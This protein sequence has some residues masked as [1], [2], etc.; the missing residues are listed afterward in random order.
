MPGHLQDPSSQWDGRY[1][2]PHQS[3]ER[4]AELQGPWVPFG[5]FDQAID[6]F[7]DGSFWIIRAPGHMP[8]NLCAAARVHGGHWIVLGSDC[9]HSREIYKGIHDFGYFALPDGRAACLHADV[10]AAR[11]T[12]ERITIMETVHGAHIAFAHDA[13]WMVAAEDPVLMSLL[14]ERLQAAARERIP[15]GEVA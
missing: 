3:T 6:Y 5:P 15:F 11:D 4:W 7:Q 2:D 9:C 1:F 8:G 14:G 13:S 12:I 10:Q